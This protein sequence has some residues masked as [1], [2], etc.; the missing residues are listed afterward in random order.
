MRSISCVGTWLTD[1][2]DDLPKVDV[3]TLVLHGS[4]DRIL[5]SDSTAARLP[6]LIKDLTLVTVE[7]AR[8]ISAGLTPT[9]STRPSWNS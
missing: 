4:E 5:P 3:P 1:F 6:G 8:T 7:A 2:R 9:K